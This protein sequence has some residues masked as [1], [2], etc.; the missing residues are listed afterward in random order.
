VATERWEILDANMLP[1]TTAT[2]VQIVCPIVA[3]AAT[4]SAFLCV[5]SCTR[6]LKI[7]NKSTKK[8]NT[9]QKQNQNPPTN[10]KY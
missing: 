2:E 8:T 3:P 10:I 5:A 9:E 4:P 6:K 1:P 7:M